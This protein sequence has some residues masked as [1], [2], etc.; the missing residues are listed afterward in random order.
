VPEL[1]ADTLAALRTHRWPGNVRELRNVLERAVV[2]SPPGTLGIEALAGREG[3]L[4]GTATGSQLPFPAPMHDIVRAAAM[5]MLELT[6]GNK[7]EAARRLG[8][9]RPRLQRLLDGKLD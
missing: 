8:I 4:P 9:S 5:A 3:G 1:G 2:L 6:A 7:S